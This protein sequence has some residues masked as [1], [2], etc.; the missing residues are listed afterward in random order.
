MKGLYTGSIE[1][2]E[3]EGWDWAEDN[4]PQAKAGFGLVQVGD[5]VTDPEC[6]V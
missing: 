2:L 1:R 5:L 4:L 6:P 3:K